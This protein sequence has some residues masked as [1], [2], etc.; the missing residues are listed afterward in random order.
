MHAIGS[1]QNFRL[2]L[3]KAVDDRRHAHVRRTDAPDR[4]ETGRC[5]KGYYRLDSIGKIPRNT[6]AANNTQPA[7]RKRHR[8]DLPGQLGPRMLAHLSEFIFADDSWM[9]RG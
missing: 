8:C 5:K 3:T 7:K 4:A 1:D 9:A 2:D 6:I